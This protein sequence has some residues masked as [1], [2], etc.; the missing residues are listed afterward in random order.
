MS[1]PR[2]K[3]RVIEV[4]SLIFF[5]VLII[6]VMSATGCSPVKGY[7][8]PERPESETATITPFLIT[9][10][11]IPHSARIDDIPFGENGIV[12][13]P[14]K[15]RIEF[16]F[17]R[18]G[19]KLGCDRFSTFD[20]AAYNMCLSDKKTRE[21]CSCW[22]Y[23]TVKERCDHEVRDVT[24]RENFSLIAGRKYRL[25]G[26]GNFA[27]PQLELVSDPDQKPVT[28][29]S[30]TTERS[31]SQPFEETVGTGRFLAEQYGV[32]TACD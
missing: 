25:I 28:R 27:K 24:C 8:G 14:G 2:A 26:T 17:T 20:D 29:L 31:A 16:I 10:Y 3:R 23:V 7:A 5:S 19:G 30:C 22:D 4:P 18:K 6:S 32:R 1:Q 12:L 11:D 21:N 9:E 13:L 15:H